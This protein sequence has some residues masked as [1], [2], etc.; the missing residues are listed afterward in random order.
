MTIVRFASI[1]GHQLIKNV[2]RLAEGSLHFLSMISKHCNTINILTNVT[3]SVS[4]ISGKCK[5]CLL[6]LDLRWTLTI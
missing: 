4:S 5:F 2:T 3:E 6:L 1:L